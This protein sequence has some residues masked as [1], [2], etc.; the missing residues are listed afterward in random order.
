MFGIVNEDFK[1]WEW[2]Y[3]FNVLASSCVHS[4]K[5]KYLIVVVININS[6]L[7]ILDNMRIRLRVSF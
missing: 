4:E 5:I 6:D 2:E 3:L 7:D 1:K